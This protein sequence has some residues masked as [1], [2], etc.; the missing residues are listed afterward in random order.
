MKI[1]Q[2]SWAVVLVGALTPAQSAEDE[3]YRDPADLGKVNPFARLYNYRLDAPVA[4]AGG[5]KP[6]PPI[7][8]TPP[9]FPGLVE[10]R[11]D[12]NRILTPEDLLL[13]TAMPLR[14]DLSNLGGRILYSPAPRDT[15][16]VD[17]IVLN[18]GRVLGVQNYR[19]DLDAHLA[20]QP[21][22]PHVLAAFA[23]IAAAPPPAPGAPAAVIPGPRPD[24]VPM[25]PEN[26][27]P[28]TDLFLPLCE[29]RH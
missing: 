29:G 1:I 22:P 5:G 21:L 3:T 11:M 2:I 17:R 18:P 14:K 13:M 16:L 6:W 19:A 24:P 4:V 20:N 26:S 8:E 25:P 28:G 27:S 9:Y 15:T 23:A 7:P 10:T 12:V